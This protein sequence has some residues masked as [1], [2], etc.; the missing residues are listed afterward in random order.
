MQTVYVRCLQGL[1]IIIYSSQTIAINRREYTDP[2]D[3]F[4]TRFFF[5][6]KHCVLSQQSFFFPHISTDNLHL[7]VQRVQPDLDM[8]QEPYFFL[9]LNNSLN[10]DWELFSPCKLRD[11]LLEKFGLCDCILGTEVTVLLLNL[12]LYPPR[13]HE[14]ACSGF[15]RH[16]WRF[17]TEEVQTGRDRSSPDVHFCLPGCLL[18]ACCSSFHPLWYGRG[19]RSDSHISGVS[20]RLFFFFFFNCRP[21]VASR[22]FSWG[23]VRCLLQGSPIVLRPSDAFVAMQRG[24]FVLGEAVGPSVRFQ[25]D[26]LRLALPG[27][28]PDLHR[29]WQRNGKGTALQMFQTHVY[30][31]RQLNS[32]KNPKC[33][34]RIMLV[35][36]I[37]QLHVPWNKH[38]CLSSGLPGV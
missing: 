36:F 3:L 13:Y 30:E 16:Y 27:W 5:L 8:L 23:D 26:D 14:P 32:S 10:F 9:F 31:T 17:R 22:I 38:T 28:L 35:L 11:V 6:W 29:L 24:L 20:G 1:L 21:E 12:F 33:P 4:Q 7:L 18:S 15:R 37:K 2:S 25:R 19:G 34:N